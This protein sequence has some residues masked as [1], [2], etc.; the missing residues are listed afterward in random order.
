LT[1][2]SP[3]FGADSDQASDL[4]DSQIVDEATFEL[5]DKHL[6]VVRGSLPGIDRKVNLLI[7]TG[8]TATLVNRRLARRAGLPNLP[9]MGIKLSAFGYG[10]KVERVLL[11]ELQLGR[12]VITRSCLAADLPLKD[13]DIVVGLDILRGTSLTIDYEKSKVVFGGSS[14]SQASVVLENEQDLVIVPVTINGQTVRLAVDTGAH[15][16]VVYRKSAESWGKRI[17]GEKR[18]K[19]AHSGGFVQARQ[20]TL[21]ILKIGGMAIERPTLSILETE[22]RTS[23]IDG[24]LAA[25]SLGVTRI[26][27]DFQRQAFSIE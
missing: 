3:L 12:R 20:V 7:D 19:V 1:E 10:M 18:V 5:R 23:K 24:F 4:S 9:D 22:N 11:R 13:I 27:F 15:S 16:T 26:H 17:I 14:A 21:S 2:L 8:A 6:I 25:A